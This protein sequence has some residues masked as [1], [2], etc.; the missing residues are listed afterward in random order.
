MYIWEGTKSQFIFKRIKKIDK[1][2][3]NLL[4]FFSYI[5]QQSTFFII[6]FDSGLTRVKLFYKNM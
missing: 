6:C 3:E 4:S 2:N 5:Y 1:N